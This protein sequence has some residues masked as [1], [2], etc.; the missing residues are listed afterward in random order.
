MGSSRFLFYIAMS[1]E[2]T[3]LVE[4]VAL[5]K[6]KW[7]GNLKS[8]VYMQGKISKEVDCNISIADEISGRQ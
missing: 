5:N 8:V 6:V 2:I 1:L 7:N 4:F 3:N